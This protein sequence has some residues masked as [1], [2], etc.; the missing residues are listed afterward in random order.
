MGFLRFFSVAMAFCAMSAEASMEFN[1]SQFLFSGRW[2]HASSYSRT[3]A[4][5]AMVQFN[6]VASSLDLELEG[7]ARWRLDQD[8]KQLAIFVTDRK[9]VK[10][11]KVAGDGKSHLYRLIKISESNPGGVILHTIATDKKGKLMAAPKFANRRIEFIG[12]SFTVGYGCEGHVADQEDH[13]FETTNTSKSYA[14][15]LADGFKADFQINAFSG[16]GLVRNYDNIVP[17]WKIPRLYKYTAPG[18]APEDVSKTSDE[19]SLLWNFDSFHPQVV[20]MFIGINDFQGNPPYGDKDEF[21]K[22]YREMIKDLRLKHPGVK[23]L[24]VSTKV[25]PNDDLTPTVKSIYETEIADGNK[26]LEFLE[27]RTTNEGLHGHPTERSQV[28]LANT[29]RPIVGR[30]GKWMSR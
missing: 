21:K 20:V 12:D 15:L 7:H 16:R 14:F 8:G 26:D 24:L 19:S 17:E 30:L 2:D 1:S 4:P 18:F 3:S 22:A 11:V 13:V 28:D 25:W 23:F 9:T 10:N 6:A 29:I 27:V 5:G